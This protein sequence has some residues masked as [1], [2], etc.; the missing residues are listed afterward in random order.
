MTEHTADCRSVR[1]CSELQEDKDMKVTSFQVKVMIISSIVL[2]LP[3]VFGL[4]K[5][6]A[7][8]DQMA[9]HFNLSGQADGWASKGF[10]VFGFPLMLL[11]TM[12]PRMPFVT[13]LIIFGLF[14][15]M[16]IILFRRTIKYAFIK[17]KRSKKAQTK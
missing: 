12:A 13:W 7:L 4:I 9:V 15:V 5:W 17:G 11:A 10:A 16:Q 2:L 14:V 8:P 6:S 3:I 1:L